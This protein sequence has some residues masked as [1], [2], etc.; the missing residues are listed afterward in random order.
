MMI[1]AATVQYFESCEVIDDTARNIVLAYFP[2]GT[3]SS[4]L[5][6]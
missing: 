2:P 6:Q 1:S 5:V 3:Y 4:K